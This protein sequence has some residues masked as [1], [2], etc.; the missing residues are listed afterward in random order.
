MAM[1]KIS[2]YTEMQNKY[3]GDC[4][5]IY[6][7]QSQYKG[8]NKRSGAD[9]GRVTSFVAAVAG[10]HLCILALN[11]VNIVAVTTILVLHVGNDPKINFQGR[12]TTRL[13][14]GVSVIPRD[15]VHRWLSQS[16]F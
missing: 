10:G 1:N 3:C 14:S 12:D 6:P 11:E 15:L 13:G 5:G 16:V 2:N 7:I 8:N 4:S 9:E